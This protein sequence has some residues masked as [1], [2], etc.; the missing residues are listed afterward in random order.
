MMK[1]KIEVSAQVTLMVILGITLRILR[2]GHA[3]SAVLYSYYA[4]GGCET[5]LHLSEGRF[6]FIWCP[7]HKVVEHNIIL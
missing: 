7:R 5:M 4:L 3:V 1:H 6:L 2:M